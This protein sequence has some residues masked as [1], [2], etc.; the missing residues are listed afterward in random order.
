MPR[1]ALESMHD[2]LAKG[3]QKKQ[4]KLLST[5]TLLWSNLTFIHKVPS[6]EEEPVTILVAGLQGKCCSNLVL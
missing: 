6:I 2:L 4:R 1:E 3:V 5:D